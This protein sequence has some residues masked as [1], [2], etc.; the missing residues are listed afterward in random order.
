MAVLG[1]LLLMYVAANS[2][3][4]GVTGHDRPEGG[5]VVESVAPDTG[6]ANAGIAASARG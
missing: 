6:A 1:L 2:P 4:L 3:V 5:F